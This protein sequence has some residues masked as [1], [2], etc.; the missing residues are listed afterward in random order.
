MPMPITDLLQRTL[1]DLRISVTDRC[2][3]RCNYCMPAELYD[4]HR[5][6]PK[7][8][9]LDFEEIARL[10]RLFATLGVRKLRL[11][12][13][14]PLLRRE[15]D[16]LVRALAKIPGIDD[17]ALTTNGLLLPAQAAGLRAA[18]LRRLTVSLDAL[19]DA[20]FAR[21]NGRG[22]PVAEVLAG[23]A[24]AEAAGFTRIKINAVIERG[25]NDGEVL[26]LAEHFRGTGHVLRFIEFMDV[27]ESN[28]WKMERVVSATEIARLIDARFPLEPLERERDPETALRYR[29]RD[30]AGE[31]GIIASVTRP[32]CGACSRARLSAKGELFTCLFAA[33]GFDLRALLRG[34][35]TDLEILRAL[36]QRWGARED[37]YSERRAEAAARGESLPKVEMSY[38]GG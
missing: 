34:G 18:G 2:N 21:M 11:T 13:G 14:E 30:G 20:I 19:D 16:R 1:S 28:G 22:V 12:G 31:I 38:I 32:F 37:R 5:F 15:L 4:G 36:E 26:R 10:A 17:L 27:G 25:V 33:S 8:E 7:Q 3:L 9:I 24:A 29:Y 6:L 23:L 35:A